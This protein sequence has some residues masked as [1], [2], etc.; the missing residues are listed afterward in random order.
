MRKSKKVKVDEPDGAAAK[1]LNDKKPKQPLWVLFT[2]PHATIE[3][4]RES[5]QSFQP[6]CNQALSVAVAA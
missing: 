2:S 1:A 4:V 6:S 3:K 5:G